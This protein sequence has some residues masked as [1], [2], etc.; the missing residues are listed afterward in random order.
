MSF[1]EI[2]FKLMPTDEAGR[3]L[4]LPKETKLSLGEGYISP[5]GQWMVPCKDSKGNRIYIRA[6]EYLAGK[7]MGYSI[8]RTRGCANPSHYNEAFEMNLD[9]KFLQILNHVYENHE[10]VVMAC[11]DKRDAERIRARFYRFLNKAD[12]KFKAELTIRLRSE[13]PDDNLNFYISIE[14]KSCA[15]RLGEKA[16][17]D[18]NFRFDEILKTINPIPKPEQ[19]KLEQAKPKSNILPF[20]NLFHGEIGDSFWQEM[21]NVLG[22]DL[23]NPEADQSESIIRDIYNLDNE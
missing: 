5:A 17:D 4:C 22:E 1:D 20:E 18:L 2:I 9:E 14:I 7:P 8:C 6:V 15:K 16:K 3:C 21:E 11:V 12:P 10:K 23:I 19:A 13:G